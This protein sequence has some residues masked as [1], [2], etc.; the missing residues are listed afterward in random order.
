MSPFINFTDKGQDILVETLSRNT[1]RM[2]MRGFRKTNKEIARQ[3]NQI[4]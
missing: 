1:V 4:K 2:E 3:P